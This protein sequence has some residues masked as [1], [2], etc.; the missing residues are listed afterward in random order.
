[1]PVKIFFCYAHEDKKLLAELKKHLTGMQRSGLIETRYDG[2]INAGSE[3][4]LRIF[5][6]CRYYP[7]AY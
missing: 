5:E 1:M 7:F 6:Y 2:D 4:E 3:W